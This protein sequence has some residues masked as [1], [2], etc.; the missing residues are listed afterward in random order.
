MKTFDTIILGLGAMGSAAA[1]ACARAG[2]KVLGLEQF[3]FVHD[4]GSSHGQ[5]RIIREVYYEHPAYVPLVQ[6]AFQRWVDLEQRAGVRLLTRCPCA[7][8]GPP[9]SEIIRGVQAATRAHGLAAETWDARTLRERLPQFT[10]PNDYVTV[11]EVNAGWLQ[12]ED[13]VRAQLEQARLHGAELHEQERVIT[14]TSRGA[15][16]EVRSERDVYHAANLIITAG[17]WAGE[18]LR[19]L[20]LPLKVMRQLQLWFTPPPSEP[21]RAPAFPIF[22]VDTPDG[23]YYGI[24]ADAG[25]GVKLAQHYGA[26]ELDRPEQIDRTITDS[27]VEPI[28]MFQ[29]RHLPALAGAPLTAAAVCIY[30]LTPDRHFLIDRH[31]DHNNVVLAAGFSGHGFKFAPVIGAILGD[32]SGHRNPQRELELFKLRD[33][34]K[35]PRTK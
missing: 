10:L 31:P 16:I 26:P 33:V 22:I 19:D 5:S 2:R 1:E 32:L 11:V 28:R 25:P 7:N 34:R 15:S 17:P 8:I 30:T 4:R 29:Q 20:G 6:E 12:V 35:E 27:D 24:P 21:F 9:D 14:W 13:C 23:A 18:V 3:D